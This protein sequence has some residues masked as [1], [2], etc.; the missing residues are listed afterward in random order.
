MWVKTAT[1]NLLNLA[2]VGEI[3]LEVD[4]PGVKVAA[5]P[6]AGVRAVLFRGTASDAQRF[7]D[8]LEARLTRDEK[9][10]A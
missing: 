1:G 4:E 5:Y 9:G 10:D 2:N 8:D 7:L 3:N 6:R